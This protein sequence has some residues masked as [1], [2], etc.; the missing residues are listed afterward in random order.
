M[1]GDNISDQIELKKYVCFL[2]ALSFLSHLSTDA[3][4]RVILEA[5]YWTWQSLGQPESYSVI[6]QNGVNTELI[7]LYLDIE[8]SGFLSTAVSIT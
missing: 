2:K 1:G 7:S 4:S 5:T 6:W 8:I 3:N